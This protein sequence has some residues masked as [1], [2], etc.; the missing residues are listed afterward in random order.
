MLILH[1]DIAMDDESEE[2][3]GPMLHEKERPG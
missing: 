1:W 3:Q 2:I